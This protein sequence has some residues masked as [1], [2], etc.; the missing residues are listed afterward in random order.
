MEVY[1]AEENYVLTVKGGEFY[2]L[3]SVPRAIISMT[4]PVP[5]KMWT[6][7]D[8]KDTSLIP[9]DENIVTTEIREFM[10]DDRRI[11]ILFFKYH[12]YE[13]GY[14][15]GEAEFFVT[16]EYINEKMNLLKKTHRIT[17]YCWDES[18]PTW[19]KIDKNR[20]YRKA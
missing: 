18:V 8:I 14:C 20:H 16:E 7:P 10:C 15:S 19:K 11:H 3:D 12:R 13:P 1:R 6:I 2:E 9:G 17:E 5:T 4:R